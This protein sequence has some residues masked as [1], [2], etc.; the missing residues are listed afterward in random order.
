[1]ILNL[2]HLENENETCNLKRTHPS[3]ALLVL[4]F[5]LQPHWRNQGYGHTYFLWLGILSSILISFRVK[6]YSTCISAAAGGNNIG[7]SIR[8][9]AFDSAQTLPDPAKKIQ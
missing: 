5:L 6:R 7:D 9:S 4:L 8:D 1:M 3:A 2:R